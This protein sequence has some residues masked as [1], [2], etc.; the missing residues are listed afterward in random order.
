MV[1]VFVMGGCSDSETLQSCEKLPLGPKRGRIYPKEIKTLEADSANFF[2][3]RVVAPARVS[4]SGDDHWQP[5]GSSE[6]ICYSHHQ[7]QQ[8]ND[9]CCHPH[10]H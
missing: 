4:G 1:Q 8:Q 2:M 7:H 3:A 10:L 5:V 9:R 6:E